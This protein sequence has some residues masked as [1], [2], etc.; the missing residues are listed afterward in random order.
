MI[1]SS[2]LL[3][4]QW[5][6]GPE[7]LNV[8]A[9]GDPKNPCVIS[10]VGTGATMNSM[11]PVLEDLADLGLYVINFNPRDSVG[12]GPFEAIK[13]KL[14][15][16]PATKDKDLMQE[17]MKLFGEDGSM[18][19]DSD[20]YAPYNWYDMAED[21]KAVM[22]VN[23]IGKASI[24]GFST[25]GATAQLMCAHLS[26]R[27]NSAI[28]CSSGFDLLPSGAAPAENPEIAAAMAEMATLTPDSD[29]DERV[30]KMLPVSL[31]MWEVTK[32]RGD[33]WEVKLRQAIEED[34]KHK[35]LDIYGG[36][37]PFATLA[38][39]SIAKAG[40]KHQE[41]LK[42]SSV[43]CLIIGGQNDPF[44]AFA[45]TQKLYDHMKQGAVE[46]GLKEADTRELDQ[47]AKVYA[48]KEG[49]R[50]VLQFIVH[51]FGHILGPRSM[52]TD[53]LLGIVD[54]VKNNSPHA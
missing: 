44:V 50:E 21:V 33:P 11:T 25:A 5:K 6:L 35:W 7:Q 34:H 18:K 42:N 24:I 54:F 45:Q 28:I 29:L 39:A 26:D 20:F 14:E 31:N 38:W 17:M 46:R 9:H 2:D 27:L 16:D 1:G 8:R 10:I 48:M 13:K 3:K 32:G 40:G 23:G 12:T 43:P 4:E 37:N 49:E 47:G 51:D 19:L 53:L 30:K 36:M 52:R 41:A 15:D 22:D